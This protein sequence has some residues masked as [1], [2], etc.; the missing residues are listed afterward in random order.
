MRSENDGRDSEAACCPF[1]LVIEEAFV[2]RY[3]MMACGWD[4]TS[5]KALPIEQTPCESDWVELSVSKHTKS[6][7]ELQR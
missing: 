4:Q 6:R 1:V 5:K 2:V 3:V 7:R